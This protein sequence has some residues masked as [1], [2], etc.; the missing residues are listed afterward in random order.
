MLAINKF[1]DIS[2]NIFDTN[3]KQF[4]EFNLISNFI[5][6]TY[7]TAHCKVGAYHWIFGGWNSPKLVAR[8]E[9]LN[10]R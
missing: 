2:N 6:A 10:L 4:K 1:Y 8:F 9:Q 5:H 7:H 3:Q